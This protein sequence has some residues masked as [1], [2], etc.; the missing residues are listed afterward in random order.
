M[1]IGSSSERQRRI[2]RLHLSQRSIDR[3]CSVADLERACPMQLF[4]PMTEENR[5]LISRTTAVARMQAAITAADTAYQALARARAELKRLDDEREAE[6][7]AGLDAALAVE[8]EA[9]ANELADEA[10]RLSDAQDGLPEALATL[11]GMI[12]D[13]RA[14]ALAPLR[15]SARRLRPPAPGALECLTEIG[16]RP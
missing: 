6:L 10:E 8:D 13:L 15:R 9:R 12:E 3:A 1:R 16:G 14:N 11:E 7:E 4:R 2:D 5:R